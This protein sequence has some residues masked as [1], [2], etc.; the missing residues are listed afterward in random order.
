MDD[1]LEITS[2]CL[3]PFDRLEERTEVPLAEPARALPLDDLVEHGRTVL[4]VAGKDLQQVAVR[5]PI[6]EDAEVLEN[7]ERLVDLADALL[8]LLVV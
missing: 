5:V 3:L 2:G 6:D 7:V 1:G 8:K 4:H